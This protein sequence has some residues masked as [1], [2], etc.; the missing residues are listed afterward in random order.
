MIRN[1]INA[2]E[3]RVIGR[4]HWIFPD[5]VLIWLPVWKNNQFS[6]Y[7]II[8]SSPFISTRKK[9]LEKNH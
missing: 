5:N 2:T 9:S 7:H 1:P 4:E 3:C 8:F 6:I